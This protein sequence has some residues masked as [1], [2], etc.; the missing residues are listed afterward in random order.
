MT[1]NNKIYEE[2]I[3]KTRLYM[4]VEHHE[5]ISREHINDALSEFYELLYLFTLNE[6]WSFSMSTVHDKIWQLSILDT[7]YYKKICDFVCEK[8]NIKNHIIHYEPNKKFGF[9]N[10]IIRKINIVN[11]YKNVYNKNPHKY[12]WKELCNIPPDMCP[13]NN[14]EF[15]NTEQPLFAN[16]TSRIQITNVMTKDVYNMQ[17]NENSKIRQIKNKLSKMLKIQAI[18]IKLINNGHI[19]DDNKILD[20]ILNSENKIIYALIR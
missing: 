13:F 6:R 2:N 15:I 19:I 5:I 12:F 18:D 14:N 8:N 3:A 11:K 20:D 10:L 7:F 4:N 16:T 1:N 9:D 17:I